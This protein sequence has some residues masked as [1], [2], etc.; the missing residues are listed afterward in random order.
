MPLEA[1]QYKD[2][3]LMTIKSDPI[4]RQ[5]WDRYCKENYYANSIDFNKVIDVLINIVN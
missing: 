4:M 5:R 1:M 3:I 2:K